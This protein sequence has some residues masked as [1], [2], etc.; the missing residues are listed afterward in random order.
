MTRK[1][2]FGTRS[3]D[4]FD[5]EGFFEALLKRQGGAPMPPSM[6]KL[7]MMVSGLAVVA[8]IAAVVWATWPSDKG[9]VD[10]NML[11]VMR[12][13][14][15]SYKIK[16]DD[17]GGMVVPNKDSTI[18]DTLNAGGNKK[19]VE[20]LLDDVEE[21]MTKEEAFG[22]EVEP[23]E[24]IS[25]VKTEEPKVEPK[26][27]TKVESKEVPLSPVIAKAEEKTE[28]KEDLEP[29]PKVEAKAEAK[30]EPVKSA[31]GS[32]YIQLAAVKSDADAKSK[33]TKLQSQH[34]VL[35]SLSLRVQKA[36]LGAKGTFYRVQAGPMSPG[37]AQGACAKIKAA[38]GDCLVIK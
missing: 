13:E 28:P 27:E 21:P 25:D 19:T 38:K 14:V 12:A 24:E 11:P 6:A 9:R 36:E 30:P 32:S 26:V 20:N 8:T 23:E 33:W 4:S 35:K 7:L 29:A 16:P 22:D 5:D 37:D 2:Q 3:Q 31:S 17:P 1:K 15:E 10:E 34:S 18:F